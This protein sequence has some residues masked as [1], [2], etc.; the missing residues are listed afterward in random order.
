MRLLQ[1][2]YGD[3]V[4]E[5]SNGAIGE[6]GNDDEGMFWTNPTLKNLWASSALLHPNLSSCFR[7][8]IN[9]R[10]NVVPYF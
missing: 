3:S 9:L 7:N 5:S 4:V 1:R 6:H 10:G 2:Y 8:S